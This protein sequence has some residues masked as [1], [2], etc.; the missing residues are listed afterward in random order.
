MGITPDSVKA[1][2]VYAS[3]GVG[4]PIAAGRAGQGRAGP[5][6][7]RQGK[8]TC[9]ARH[10]MGPVTSGGSSE[11]QVVGRVVREVEVAVPM[12]TGSNSGAGAREVEGR[13]GQGEVHGPEQHASP[14]QATCKE[15]RGC[16]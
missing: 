3:R 12:R 11:V 1:P 8:H 16:M 6:R 5:G 13:A 4:E 2:H 9:S 14:K 7:A 15:Q 10:G